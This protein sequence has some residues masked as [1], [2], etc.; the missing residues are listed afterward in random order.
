MRTRSRRN[1]GHAFDVKRG[2]IGLIPRLVVLPDV[3]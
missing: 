3:D 1:V 2:G